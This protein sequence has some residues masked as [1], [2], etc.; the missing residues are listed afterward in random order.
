MWPDDAQYPIEA[1]VKQGDIHWALTQ[2]P[3]LRV[4]NGTSILKAFL[5][6]AAPSISLST[7]Y[8]DIRIEVQ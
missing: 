3:S 6:E 1:Q 7:T 5:E 4:E 8:K 2:E